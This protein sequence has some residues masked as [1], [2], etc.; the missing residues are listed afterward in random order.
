LPFHGTVSA[1]GK[2]VNGG[3]RSICDGTGLKSNRWTWSIRSKR[4]GARK[5][6]AAP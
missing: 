6:A 2:P 5:A 1:H 4:S 3:K